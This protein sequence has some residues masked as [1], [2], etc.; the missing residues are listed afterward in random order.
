MIQLDM[1]GAG[2]ATLNIDGNTSLSARIKHIAETLGIEA[3]I[4]NTGGSDHVP[5]LSAGV[6]A[7]A[8]IWEIYQMR[9]LTITGPGTRSEA[10]DD[11]RLRSAAQIA[12]L[13]IL[14]WSKVNPQSK[15]C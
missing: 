3:R 9:R 1:I 8:L 7:S 11:E 15:R 14:T 10:I 12:E 6:P 5:F 13:T 2:S 4:T